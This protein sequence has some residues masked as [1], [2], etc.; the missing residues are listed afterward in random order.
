MIAWA[1]IADAKMAGEFDGTGGGDG[2]PELSMMFEMYRRN[3][4]NP[5]TDWLD[6]SGDVRDRV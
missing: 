3:H 2:A 4:P 6:P 5:P 1:L